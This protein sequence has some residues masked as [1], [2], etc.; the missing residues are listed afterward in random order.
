MRGTS[1]LQKVLYL[2]MLV[3]GIYILYKAGRILLDSGAAQRA[4]DSGEVQRNL[5]D[6]AMRT[7]APGYTAAVEG[8]G[9]PDWLAG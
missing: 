6:A 8:R 9:M 4:L 7:Y 2:I 3:L 5:E 1:G